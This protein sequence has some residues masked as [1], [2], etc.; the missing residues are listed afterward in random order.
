M[1]ISIIGTGSVGQ[2]LASK[3]HSLGHEIMIGTRDVRQSLSRTEKDRYGY[4]GFGEWIKE[5]K[6]IKVGT[7]KEAAAYGEILVN[8]TQG[9]SSIATFQSADPGDL[10]GKIIIDIANPL[11][12]SQGFLQLI[13][14]LSNSNSL[15]EE[16]QK[17]FPKAMVVKTFNTMWCGLMVDPGMIGNG[18]HVNFLCGNDQDAKEKVRSLLHEIGWKDEYLVDLGDIAA[19]RGTEAVLLLWIRLM[20]LKQTGAFNFRITG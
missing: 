3:F 17:S 5:N 19:S 12:F 9:A 20:N 7:I 6:G 18:E 14:A 4:P 2:T 11:D 10:A 13:P 15:G 8:A 16:M 1:K